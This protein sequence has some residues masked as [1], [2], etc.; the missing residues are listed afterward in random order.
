[1][2]HRNFDF[3]QDLGRY[4][5]MRTIGYLLGIPE[6]D[7]EALRDKIDA[8]LRLAE[9]APGEDRRDMLVNAEELYA[10]YIDWRAKH[11]S[12]D[13]MTALLTVEFEDETGVRRRLS[14]EEVLTYT[15]MLSS[16]GN[17]TT[18]RLIGWTGKLL[19]EHP[20]ARRQ[21]AA[22]RTLIPNAIEEILRYEAPS[23]I[24]ARSVAD[25]VELY[26]HLV[27]EGSVMVLL[28]G[29]ANRDERRFPHPDRFDIHRNIGHHLSFGYSLHFCL[30]A[31]LA[32]LEARVALDE[33]L[34][35]WTDWEVDYSNA[36]QGR[37]STV[38]GWERLPVFVN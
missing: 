33:V 6:S 38:R 3:V 37:T 23:P 8:G 20:E 4:V 11:P 25:D 7:Q 16:A 21:I 32:R 27:A 15:N 14:R 28:T 36:V 22:D 24:Q 12:N 1:V 34:N 31:A 35:R 17:E 30:G 26:G 5:P 10:E 29:S 2:G 13:L 9:G 19:A 18:A